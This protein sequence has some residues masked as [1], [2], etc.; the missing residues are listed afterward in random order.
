MSAVI[1]HTL[2]ITQDSI[3]LEKIEGRI[4]KWGSGVIHEKK[5]KWGIID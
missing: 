2:H 1:L 3:E 5:L 4:T